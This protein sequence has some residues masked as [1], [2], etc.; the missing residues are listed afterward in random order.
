LGASAKAR[1]EVVMRAMMR[2]KN[3]RGNM[4]AP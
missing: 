1:C 2:K 4:V 3:A